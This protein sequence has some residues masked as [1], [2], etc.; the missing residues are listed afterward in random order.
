[1]TRKWCSVEE[2]LWIHS[3]HCSFYMY[4]NPELPFEPDAIRTKAVT[5]SG[6]IPISIVFSGSFVAPDS[7]CPTNTQQPESTC[8][9]IRL[10]SA[11]SPYKSIPQVACFEHW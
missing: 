4:N 3:R 1:M 11:L 6:I 8:H 7:T 10:H 2:W 9:P 5:D